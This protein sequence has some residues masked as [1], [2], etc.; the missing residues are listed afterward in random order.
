MMRENRTRETIQTVCPKCQRYLSEGTCTCTA[1]PQP[2]K[3]GG[4]GARERLEAW[5]ALLSTTRPRN[6]VAHMIEREKGLRLAADIRALLSEPQRLA[7]RVG[8]L[9]PETVEIL[10]AIET[11]LR[12]RGNVI[13]SANPRAASGFWRRADAVE[14]AIG[15]L[16]TS[17]GAADE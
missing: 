11:D 12:G 17:T 15:R 13:Q 14:A 4:E 16:A 3:E 9:P 5:A 10:R 2:L 8:G 7:E 6:I 1:N